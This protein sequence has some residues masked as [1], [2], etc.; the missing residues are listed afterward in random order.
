MEIESRDFT[1]E[2]TD[3][4]GRLLSIGNRVSIQAVASCVT[5][6]PEE[7]RARLFDSD[8]RET[9]PAG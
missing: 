3:N 5:E 8:N 2:P 4:F 9:S 6:L 1:L 7:D